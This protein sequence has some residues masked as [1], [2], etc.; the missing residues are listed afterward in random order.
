MVALARVLLDDGTEVYV[1]TGQTGLVSP[2]GKTSIEQ[3]PQSAATLESAAAGAGAIAR[4]IRQQLH[5]DKLELEIS[6]GLTGEVG[7]FFAKS[8]VEGVVKLKLSWEEKDVVGH[9]QPST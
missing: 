5:P 1:E 7:W 2:R 8:N 3:L 6:L 4:N 9:D